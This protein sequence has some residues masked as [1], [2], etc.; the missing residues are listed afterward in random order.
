MLKYQN[1]NFNPHAEIM[2]CIQRSQSRKL[3][4]DF[5]IDHPEFD[6][7]QLEGRINLDAV[8]VLQTRGGYHVLVRLDR[9]AEAYQ[10]TFYRAL[11]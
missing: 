3:Y 1:Q 8:D 4:L 5:D 11:N 6:L 2:S 10:K 7:R 9:V